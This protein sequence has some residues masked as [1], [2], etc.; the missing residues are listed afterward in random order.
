MSVFTV[1]DREQPNVTA[2]ADVDDA[3]SDTTSLKSSILNYTYSNGRRYAAFR[4]GE[5][6]LPK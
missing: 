3:A 5:Y 4:E 2:L 1:A 6:L